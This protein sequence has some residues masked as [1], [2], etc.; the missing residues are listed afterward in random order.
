MLSR[1]KKRKQSK[2]EAQTQK[3]E[4]SK[5]CQIFNLNL[6]KQ[7]KKL[8]SLETEKADRESQARF[9]ARMT[10]IEEAYTLEDED[11][12]IIAS[13]LAE[14]DE[15]EEAFASYQEKLSVVFKSKSNE[16]IQKL[17][18]EM[19]ARIQE[20]VEKRLASQASDSE[21]EAEVEELSSQVIEESLEKANA[22][23]EAIPNNNGETSEVELTLKDRF[24]EAFKNS[25]K[26]N[27]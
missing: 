22:T 19:E 27:Y 25:V 12:K 17:A 8:E 18:D 5:P 26:V 16:Y 21:V 9:D 14:I 4:L 11:R 23:E 20:E 1:L 13:E 7:S 15:S 3:E 6:K 2:P 10:V 24:A